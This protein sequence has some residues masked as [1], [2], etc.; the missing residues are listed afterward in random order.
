MSSPM[1]S[2]RSPS[3]ESNLNLSDDSVEDLNDVNL[4]DA[5]YGRSRPRHATVRVRVQGFG[6]IQ[7]RPRSGP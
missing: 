4:D 7:T 1:S 5:I 3:V 2:P 6:N